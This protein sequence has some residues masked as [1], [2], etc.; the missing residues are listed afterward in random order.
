MLHRR[1]KDAVAA[2]R[3]AVLEAGVTAEKITPPMAGQ[4]LALLYLGHADGLDGAVSRHLGSGA[5]RQGECIVA[6]NTIT[7]GLIQRPDLTFE[8]LPLDMMPPP[9]AHDPHGDAVRYLLHRISHVVTFW[10]VHWCIWA[11]ESAPEIY[12]EARTHS[13]ALASMGRLARQNP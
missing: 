9:T 7:Q 13:P 5:T 10:N 11:G 3:K 4:R 12:H 6:S 1:W 2:G 8:F